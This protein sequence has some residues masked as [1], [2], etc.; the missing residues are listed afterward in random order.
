MDTSTELYNRAGLCMDCGCLLEGRAIS[1]HAHLYSGIAKRGDLA[2][3]G[4]LGHSR[5]GAGNLRVRRLKIDLA[6]CPGC[7]WILIFVIAWVFLLNGV[8]SRKL[9]LLG[10]VGID[11]ELSFCQGLGTGR[12][13]TWTSITGAA[14]ALERYKL[15]S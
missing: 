15:I 8:V 11:V 3:Q 7:R 6:S 12:P 5:E 9:I 13:W 4:A 2:L 10:C 1:M 14:G